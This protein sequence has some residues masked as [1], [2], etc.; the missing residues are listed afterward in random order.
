MKDRPSA[1]TAMPSSSAGPDVI[2]SGTPSGKRCR[3]VWNAPPALELK[4][5]HFPSGDQAAK[6]HG[7]PC[8]PTSF[9]WELAFMG[10]TRQGCQGPPFR[11]VINAQFPSGEG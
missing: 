11:S 3:Q 2:C 8:G 4:Y 6:V 1:A 9:P 10:T 7:A 5:I